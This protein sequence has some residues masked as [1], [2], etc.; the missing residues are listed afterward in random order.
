VP[1]MGASGSAPGR[2]TDVSGSD[3]SQGRHGAFPSQRGECF[4]TVSVRYDSHYLSPGC[5]LVVPQLDAR[6]FCVRPRLDAASPLR[7]EV[8]WLRPRRARDGFLR[9]RLGLPPFPRAHVGEKEEDRD[10]CL[11]AR[12]HRPCLTL[13]RDFRINFWIALFP[14]SRSP[15]WRNLSPPHTQRVCVIC[16]RVMRLRHFR[17]AHSQRLTTSPPHA[18][19]A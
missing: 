11:P 19:R 9:R 4:R 16:S 7:R 14:A 15:T 10:P 17:L 12:A 13:I 18:R 6:T 3:V 1:K 5:A 8:L 2:W